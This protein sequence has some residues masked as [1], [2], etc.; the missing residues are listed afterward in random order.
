MRPTTAPEPNP[1][2]GAVGVVVGEWVVTDVAT[3]AV[4][5]VVGEW[6]VIDVATGAVSVVVGE[7]VV[8]DVATDELKVGTLAGTA[9][10]RKH[11]VSVL[12]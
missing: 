6:V 9:E 12:H 1:A 7:W 3:G 10:Q 4:G 8:T 2:T 5:V 11:D